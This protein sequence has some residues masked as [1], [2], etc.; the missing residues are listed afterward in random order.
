MYLLGFSIYTFTL[1]AIILAVGL[2]VDDTIVMLEND[3]SGPNVIWV[4]RQ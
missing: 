2:V 3:F 1:L 4:N